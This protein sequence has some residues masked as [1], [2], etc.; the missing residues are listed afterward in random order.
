[1]AHVFGK[2]HRCSGAAVQR[3]GVPMQLFLR[4]AHCVRSRMAWRAT[5]QKR[6]DPIDHHDAYIGTGVA[7]GA[8]WVESPS[9]DSSHDSFVPIQ[10]I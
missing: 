9:R 1:M 2:G 5:S 3:G 4:S 10:T 8:L 7:N 6:F